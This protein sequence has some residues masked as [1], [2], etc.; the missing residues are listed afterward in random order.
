MSTS[1]A[2]LTDLVDLVRSGAA[3]LGP[4]QQTRLVLVDGPAGSGKSSLAAQLGTALPAQVVHMDDLYP[5]WQGLV[6]G[7]DRLGKQIIDP[8][9]FGALARFQRYDWERGE[10]A[11]WHEV[12]AE[13]V[14]VVEGCGAGARRFDPVTTLLIWV[15][16][17]DA[18]RLRRGLARDGEAVRAEWMRWMADEASIY[19]A[20]ETRDRADVRLDGFG[21]VVNLGRA[22][23]LR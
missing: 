20:E 19:A 2:V 6:D 9:Q 8:L 13:P 7:I 17:D 18:L 14:L 16:A 3:R 21:S 10:Y 11:E 1:V 15:E 22:D 4:A 12:P 5:G 23:G